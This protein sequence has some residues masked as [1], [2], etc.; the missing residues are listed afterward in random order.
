LASPATRLVGN[1]I[2][3]VLYWVATSL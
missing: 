3:L 2:C 1:C